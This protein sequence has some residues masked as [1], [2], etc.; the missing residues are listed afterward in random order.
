MNAHP[1]TDTGESAD[2]YSATKESFMFLRW[3]SRLCLTPARQE[4]FVARGGITAGGI[5]LNTSRNLVS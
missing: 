1:D 4:Y 3:T 5:L 2:G